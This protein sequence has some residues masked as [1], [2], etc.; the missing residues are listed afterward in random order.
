MALLNAVTNV[1]TINDQDQIIN[2]NITEGYIVQ[3]RKI[4]KC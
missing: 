3:N 1:I 4:P 2:N